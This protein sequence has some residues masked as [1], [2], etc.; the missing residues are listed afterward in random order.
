MVEDREDVRIMNRPF[1]IFREMSSLA[2]E[3]LAY[4]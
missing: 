1:Q 2:V 4:Q 3:L